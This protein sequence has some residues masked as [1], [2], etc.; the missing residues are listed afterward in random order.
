M[1]VATINRIAFHYASKSNCDVNNV[2]LRSVNKRDEMK[3][4]KNGFCQIRCEGCPRVCILVTASDYFISII[5]KSRKLL[6]KIIVHAFTL[7]VSDSF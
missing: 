3:T 5:G 7:H 1:I 4:G 2:S 6:D